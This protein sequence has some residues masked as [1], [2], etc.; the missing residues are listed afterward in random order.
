MM[1]SRDII[2]F[3][4]GEGEIPLPILM[5]TY[6]EELA[7]PTIWFGQ[8]RTCVPNFRMSFEDHVNSEIRPSDRRAARPDHLLF[9]HKRSQI[10]QLMS[11]IN[12]VLRKASQGAGI[13]AD[14]ALNRAF[15]N[16]I[17]TKDNA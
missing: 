3:D 9:L 16:D 6:C 13:T 11:Q 17:V 14:Q 4:P 1:D 10:K 2:A 8:K 15:V 5:D 12:I 7:V